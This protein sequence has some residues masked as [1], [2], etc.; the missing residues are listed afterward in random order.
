[1]DIILYQD[2]NY[3]LFTVVI[4][5]S[6]FKFCMIEYSNF[7]SV[8]EPATPDILGY[9][10]IS[11]IVVKEAFSLLLKNSLSYYNKDSLLVK[12]VIGTPITWSKKVRWG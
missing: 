1:M 11:N 2:V 5:K 12:M 9:S 4:P 10:A 7:N 6:P 3:Y 8:N